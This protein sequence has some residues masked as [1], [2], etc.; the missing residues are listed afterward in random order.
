MPREPA[1]KQHIGKLL[2]AL[3]GLATVGT[4]YL[5]NQAHKIETREEIEKV[6]GEKLSGQMLVREREFVRKEDFEKVVAPINQRL[7][8][9]ADKIEELGDRSADLEGYLRAK[10]NE[11]SKEAVGFWR[12]AYR[13]SR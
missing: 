10:E 13:K 12:R 8:K 9:F 5:L 7:D 4:H 1:W 6:V 3:T 2:L 11:R